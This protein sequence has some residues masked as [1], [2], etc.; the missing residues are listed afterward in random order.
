MG[1]QKLVDAMLHDGLTDAMYGIHMGC[2]ADNIAKNITFLVRH[3]MNLH[4]LRKKK[5]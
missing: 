1:D 2:T 4:L 3:K 5:L